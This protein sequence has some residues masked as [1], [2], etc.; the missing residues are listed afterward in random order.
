[1]RLRKRF[2]Q[3]RRTY[4][5]STAAENLQAR[6]AWAP[7]QD[8][9]LFDVKE[10]APLVPKELHDLARHINSR[11]IDREEDFISFDY[12]LCRLSHARSLVDLCLGELLSAFRKA[13]G[14]ACGEM[15]YSKLDDFA[16]EHLS[17]SGRLASELILNF[18][19]LQDLPAANQESRAMNTRSF[20]MK[21]V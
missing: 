19:R 2:V 5:D 7:G 9:E 10:E 12:H 4:K 15:G 6:R 17:F 13:D 3:S 20:R 18:E 8:A 11:S 14:K 1:M 21:N 16:D